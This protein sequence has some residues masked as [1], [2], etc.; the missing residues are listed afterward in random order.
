VDVLYDP[1]NMTGIYIRNQ[2]DISYDYCS[3]LD[4]NNKNAGKYLDEIVYEQRK[5][6]IIGRQLR[7]T[8]TEAKVN[9]NAEIEAI[10]TEAKNMNKVLPI[11]SKR[12][13]ISN[14]K[15]NRREERE[16]MRAEIGITGVGQPSSAVTS[17]PI[18]KNIDDDISPR[19][20]MIKEKAGLKDD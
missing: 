3:L 8:E 19:L 13:K 12:E 17:V 5:E 11:K 6:S 18:Q 20:R 14:I 2:G 1:G 7:V 10:V 16:I 15:E 4:W 9:L